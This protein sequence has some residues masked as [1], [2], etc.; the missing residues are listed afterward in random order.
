MRSCVQSI[1]VAGVAE[2]S[3]PLGPRILAALPFLRTNRNWLSEIG[4]GIGIIIAVLLGIIAAQ[5][6]SS[7]YVDADN[8][9]KE[10]AVKQQTS[11]QGPVEPQTGILPVSETGSPSVGHNYDKNTK[12]QAQ[13]NEDLLWGDTF[14]QWLMALTGAIALGV[15]VWAVVLIRN[16]FRLTK[17]TLAEARKAIRY[18]DAFKRKRFTRFRFMAGGDVGFFDDKMIICLD[19]NAIGD[20]END[21]TCH[22]S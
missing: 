15:S 2:L 21:K 11:D 1:L 13:P 9:V 6:N 12:P 8:Q 7:K 5:L 22:P 16:T 18:R 10:N 3:E 20:V 17:A 19:G 14:A 4:I